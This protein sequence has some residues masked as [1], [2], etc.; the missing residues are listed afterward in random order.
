MNTHDTIAPAETTAQVEVYGEQEAPEGIYSGF[1]SENASYFAQAFVPLN[2]IFGNEGV[3]NI[4][5]DEADY[6]VV[7]AVRHAEGGSQED[8]VMDVDCAI[9]EAKQDSLQECL[10]ALEEVE[11]LG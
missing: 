9:L 3:M 10:A 4:V 11:S 2:E 1:V 6:T 5:S 8:G 7:V